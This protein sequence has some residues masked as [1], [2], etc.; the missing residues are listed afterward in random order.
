MDPETDK[1]HIQAYR[2]GYCD[3]WR[4]VCEEL[5]EGVPLAVLQAYWPALVKWEANSLPEEQRPVLDR[6]KKIPPS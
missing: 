5:V 3:G 6:H 1:T 4:D 2:R